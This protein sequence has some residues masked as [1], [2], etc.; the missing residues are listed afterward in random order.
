MIWLLLT[1]AGCLALGLFIGRR[2]VS[3]KDRTTLPAPE[4]DPDGEE[5]AVAAL[6]VA[7]AERDLAEAQRDRYQRQAIDLQLATNGLLS[8]R[9]ELF[10]ELRRRAN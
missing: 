2:S 1:G 6:R 5:L 8:E 7:E 10:R 9:E 4:P 3:A